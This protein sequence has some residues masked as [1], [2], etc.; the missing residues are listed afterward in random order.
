MHIVLL[1]SPGAGKG[2]QSK[3]L[4][5]KYNLE[6]IATGDI[7]RSEISKNT[8]LG[9]KAQHYVKKGML[10]PDELVVEMV[11]SRLDAGTGRWLL[12]GFPRTL[13][14]AQELDKYLTSNKQ[15]IDTV[16]YLAMPAEEVIARLTSRWTCSGC[17]DVYNLQSCK[18][19]EEGKCDK[20][21]KELIQREDDTEATVKKR[22][23]I[24][25]DLTQPLVAYFRSQHEFEEVNGNQS[26]EEVKKALC[27]RI[28]QIA[29]AGRGA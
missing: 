28:D 3:M 17:G 9:E 8:P 6:H 27:G 20:C 12:D 14:Q 16:L 19:K 24:Y 10:V 4:C 15:D 18:P 13:G 22:L 26:V 1:G 2:T 7:F 5:A 29:A 25:E 23:M 21:S 11:A